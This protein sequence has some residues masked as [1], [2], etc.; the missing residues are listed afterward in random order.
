VQPKVV[1]SFPVGQLRAEEVELD[2]D[3]AIA[4]SGF[5]GGNLFNG[6]VIASYSDESATLKYTF[7]VPYLSLKADV[8]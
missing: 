2:E 4:L 3:R 8:S 1:C 5:L 6:H 7:K